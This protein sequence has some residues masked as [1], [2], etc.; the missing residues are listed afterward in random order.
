VLAIDGGTMSV[1]GSYPRYTDDGAADP[2]RVVRTVHGDALGLWVVE[3]GRAGLGGGGD[4]WF[5]Y[6]VDPKSGDSGSPLVIDRAAFFHAPRPCEPDE[7]GWLLVH[8]VNPSV[9]NFEFTA[10]PSPPALGKVEARYIASSG[11]LCLDA[12]AG[13]VEGDP[14]K[15]LRPRSVHAPSRQSVELALTDRATDR[16]WGF[17]CTP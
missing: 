5:V 9:A 2:P 8:N 1:L 3:P 6:P 15:D 7:D 13:Q 10:V 16:R 17:R 12:L 4:T 11:G 14:P